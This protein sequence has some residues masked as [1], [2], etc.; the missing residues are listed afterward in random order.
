MFESDSQREFRQIFS[1]LTEIFNE[2]RIVNTKMDEIIGKQER[3]LSL[4]SQFQH[5]GKVSFNYQ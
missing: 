3:S 5:G 4:I 1:G 2:I